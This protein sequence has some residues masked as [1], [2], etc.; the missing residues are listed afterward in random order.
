MALD[1]NDDVISNSIIENFKSIIAEMIPTALEN[2]AITQEELDEFNALNESNRVYVSYGSPASLNWSENF[3]CDN[4]GEFADLYE[5]EEWQERTVEVAY[6]YLEEGQEEPEL[7]DR[8]FVAALFDYMGTEDDHPN[9][10]LQWFPE[11]SMIEIPKE[12]AND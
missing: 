7:S 8:I 9:V 5:T 1:F 12:A 4:D 10:S 3:D 11:L 6:C 2:N